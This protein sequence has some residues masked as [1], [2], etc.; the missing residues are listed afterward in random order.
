MLAKS[1]KSRKSSDVFRIRHTSVYLFVLLIGYVIV[2]FLFPY[3]EVDASYYLKIAFDISHGMSFYKD[4]NVQYN[5]LVMYLL[6]FLFYIFPKAGFYLINSYLL[7]IYIVNGFLFYKILGFYDLKKAIKQLFVIIMLLSFYL[8][9]GFNLYLEPFVLMFQFLAL[10]LLLKWEVNKSWQL[11]FFAG[12]CSYFAFYSKQ[13]GIFILPAFIF[14]IYINSK[15]LSNKI[16][17]F[18]YFLIVIIVPLG[19]IYIYFWLFSKIPFIEFTYKILAIKSLS[20]ED[21]VTGINY[22]LSAFLLSSINFILTAPYVT[23]IFY[24]IFRKEIRLLT[25]KSIFCFLIIFGACM[26]LFFAAYIHYFQLIFPYFLLLAAIILNEQD[27][28][29]KVKIFNLIRI[30]SSVLIVTTVNW[31]T[32]H[33]CYMYI[34]SREQKV[35]KSILQNIIPEGEK[36]YLQGIS[37]SY[38]FIC[39]Y[40]SPNYKE[41]GYRF[42]EELN[43]NIIDKSLPAQS[44]LVGDPKII[45]HEPFNKGYHLICKVNLHGGGKC[46]ILLKE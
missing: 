3:I 25:K 38:Y 36:V 11:L 12:M 44:Y 13:Y 16:Q 42:P 26:Q 33:A 14:F 45:E 39:K 46:V 34:Q 27:R 2:T 7:L 1:K 21:V 41:L 8:F 4:M 22:H 28:E 5:P 30:T 10:F 40:D 6:S 24:A 18:I 35:N 32:I 15:S 9:T 29:N 20:G 17:H 23:I 43:S 31:F 37:P 19:I